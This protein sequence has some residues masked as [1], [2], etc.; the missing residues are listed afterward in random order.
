[1]VSIKHNGGIS[2]ISNG[3][4]ADDELADFATD[5]EEITTPGQQTWIPCD[6]LNATKCNGVCEACRGT[7]RILTLVGSGRYALGSE[8]KRGHN[9]TAARKAIH[10]VVWVS[11]LQFYGCDDED[12][13]K[14]YTEL[15]SED[16]PVVLRHDNAFTIASLNNEIKRLKNAYDRLLERDTRN[17]QQLN[18]ALQELQKRKG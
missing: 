7:G 18:R 10:A 17:L 15:C 12:D 5:R 1:M 16:N 14:R 8:K 4:S 6:H 2:M 3:F 11:P 13:V 9:M